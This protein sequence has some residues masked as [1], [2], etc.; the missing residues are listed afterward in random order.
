MPNPAHPLA[1]G[2]PMALGANDAIELSEFSAQDV[3]V[4]EQQG[5]KSLVLGRRGYPVADRQV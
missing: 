4:E 3:P 2:I 1:G 5:I